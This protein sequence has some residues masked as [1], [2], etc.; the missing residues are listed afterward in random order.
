M[1]NLYGYAIYNRSSPVDLGY[2]S[3]DYWLYIVSFGSELAAVSM[4]PEQ[5][6]GTVGAYGNFGGWV[7][8]TIFSLTD[9]PTLFMTMGIVAL[10]CTSLCS[11]C[12]KE[13]KGSC[14]S[15]DIEETVTE[16]YSERTIEQNIL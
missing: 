13:P 6:S 2:S 9:T 10:I 8:L 16:S 15:H 4:L 3:V 7:F 1:F 14:A 12:L 11:F 5:I